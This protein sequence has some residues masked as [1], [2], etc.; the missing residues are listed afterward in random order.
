MCVFRLC[1]SRLLNHKDISN[2]GSDIRLDLIYSSVTFL[3]LQC[4]I[5]HNHREYCIIYNLFQLCDKKL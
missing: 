3:P 1:V 2:T 4:I 5:T